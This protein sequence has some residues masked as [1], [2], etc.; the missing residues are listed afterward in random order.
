MQLP[1]RRDVITRLG[2]GLVYQ[3]HAL[4]D[5]PKLQA[6]VGHPG[7]VVATFAEVR[8]RKNNF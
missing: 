2:W 8:E 4:T 1:L 6:F 7:D 3:I 5:D